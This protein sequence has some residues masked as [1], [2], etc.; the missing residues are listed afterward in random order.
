M[1]GAATDR[2][3]GRG[4]DDV[5][6]A[7]R[8]ACGGDDDRAA[9]R[10]AQGRE[11]RGAEHDLVGRVH[12]VPGQQGRRHRGGGR[13]A[14][15]RNLHPVKAQLAEVDAR[16]RRHGVVGVECLGELLGGKDT[17]AVGGGDRRRPVPP[18]Q[19]G[20]RHELVEARAEG[21]RRHE[22]RHG[23]RRA[24]GGGPQ[25]RPAHAALAAEREMQPCDGRD[26]QP[27]GDRRSDGGRRPPWAGRVAARP[28]R[29]EP[30]RREHRDGQQRGADHDGANEDDRRVEREARARLDRPDRADQG[31]R[32][33]P[34]GDAHRAGDPDHDREE[35]AG[36]ALGPGLERRGAER[37]EHA[38]ILRPAPN[39]PT[40]RLAG[41]EE[42]EQG[43]DRSED[44]QGEGVG[45][46]DPVRVR[47][48]G[49]DRPGLHREDLRQQ[50]DDLRL[51]RGHRA[52][53]AAQLQHR[54]GGVDAAAQQRLRERG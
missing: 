39:E 2:W 5:Q 37:A 51:G 46:E 31:E 48:R 7:S 53:I 17:D 34:P 4:P 29:R 8:L 16:P 30:D 21:Q 35:G 27:E 25:R 11:R 40:E 36:H 1:L 19:R 3:K 32:R 28:M 13:D 41:E 10:R 47:D 52:R 15:D 50:L 49:S 26:R 14:E 12:A 6:R 33:E 24:D 43:D 42:H 9:H 45:T 22:D 23:E 18:V 38:A 54:D 20:A 44:V